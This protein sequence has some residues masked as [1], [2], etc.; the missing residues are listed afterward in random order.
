[1]ATN[2]RPDRVA[3]GIREEIA[4]FLQ[5]EGVG[6]PRVTGLVTVTGVESTRDLRSA[7]VFVSYLGDEEGRAHV[8]EALT[9]LVPRLR[10]HVGRALRLRVAPELHFRLDES[11]A[12][13]ARIEDLLRQ[14]RE[15]DAAPGSLPDGSPAG[16]APGARSSADLGDDDDQD[17][18]APR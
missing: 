2:R 17:D 15:G 12:R 4:T 9:H 1:M 14:I 7:R 11:V 16:G 10:G 6:D 5:S 3:E 18:D 8:L 13:A